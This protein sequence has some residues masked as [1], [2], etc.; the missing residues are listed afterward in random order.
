M[1]H[2]VAQRDALVQAGVSIMQLQSRP[3][4]WRLKRRKIRQR[5]D[6]HSSVNL[7]SCG[8]GSGNNG[9]RLSHLLPPSPRRLCVFP[10]SSSY[11]FPSCPSFPTSGFSSQIHHSSVRLFY[12]VNLARVVI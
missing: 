8:S 9:I 3:P 2:A 1:L 7:S 5:M 10:S 12:L 4:S 11:A 6:T